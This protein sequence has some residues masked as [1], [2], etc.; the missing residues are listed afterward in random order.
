LVNSAKHNSPE[1]LQPAGAH[2]AERTP[3]RRLFEI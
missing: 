2:E 1:V 3:Q